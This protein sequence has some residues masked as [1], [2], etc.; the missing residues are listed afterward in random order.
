M[1]GGDSGE[2][3]L[4]LLVQV[5]GPGTQWRLAVGDSWPH[6]GL[7]FVRPDGHGWHPNA[8]TQRFR[9]LVRQGGLPPIRLHDLPHSAATIALSAGVDVKVVSEQLGHSTTTLTR[10][11]YQSVI[12]DTPTSAGSGSR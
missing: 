4:E 1:R 8:V 12:M 2:R 10:D 7:F 5:P 6:T 11:T 9:R 3:Q